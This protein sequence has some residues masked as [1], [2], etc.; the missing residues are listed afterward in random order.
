MTGYVF[1]HDFK[2]KNPILIYG[3]TVDEIND[4]IEIEYYGGPFV[5]YEFV[6]GSLVKIEPIHI[7]QVPKINK[8]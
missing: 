6:E 4:K 7:F 1:A 8:I 2:N 3:V 5:F